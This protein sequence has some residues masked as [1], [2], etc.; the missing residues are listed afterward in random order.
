MARVLVIEDNPANMK[1]A[2]LLLRKAGYGTLAA[3]DAEEGLRLAREQRPGLVLMDI[4]LPGMDGLQ[5]TRLLKADEATRNIKVV[6]LTAYAMKGERDNIQAAGCDGYL[7]K[8]LRYREFYAKVAEML[9]EN[10]PPI[11]PEGENP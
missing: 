4:Q 1:L 8:P 9:G 2:L 10:A 6:A 5:A 11:N 3:A 7:A